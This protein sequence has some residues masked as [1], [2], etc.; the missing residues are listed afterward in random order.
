MFYSKELRVI[1]YY[2][3]H[4]NY[5]HTEEIADWKLD[6]S[7]IY[8]DIL[9]IEYMYV[10]VMVDIHL[11]NI[12]LPGNP[13]DKAVVARY[14]NNML[15]I[16]FNFYSVTTVASFRDYFNPRTSFGYLEVL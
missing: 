2:H 1:S 5:N 13:C 12:K 15:N 3:F 11:C 9:C 4:H 10:L 14:P 7:N 6:H 8:V 16:I